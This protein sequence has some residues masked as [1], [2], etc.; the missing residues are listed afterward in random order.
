M[1][2]DHYSSC[3]CVVA[4]LDLNP[5]EIL[6]ITVATMVFLYYF[7]ILQPDGLGSTATTS[8]DC[9]LLGIL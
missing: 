9:S 3:F 7:P 6:N 5:L 8:P 4:S 1:L 2:K